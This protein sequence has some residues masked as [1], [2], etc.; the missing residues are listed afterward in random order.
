MNELNIL[1]V[2]DVKTHVRGADGKRV[3]YN[4]DASSIE[5]SL[6][7]TDIPNTPVSV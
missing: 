1:D 3:Y 7:S 2:D 4:L 5:S 6:C